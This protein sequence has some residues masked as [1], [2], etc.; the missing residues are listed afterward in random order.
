[1]HL[2]EKSSQ[3]EQIAEAQDD[4][5]GV[6]LVPAFTGLGAPYWNSEARGTLFGLT[7]ETGSAEIVRAG[8]EAVVYQ[9]ADLMQAM[10]ADG[11]EPHVLRVD[12]GMSKNGWLMQF[13]S[14]IAVIPL[15]RSANV[16]TTA[17]G[18]AM[19][20]GINIG[21][22]Q[23]E[24]ELNALRGAKTKFV[25]TMPEDVRSNYLKGWKAAVSATIA[26]AEALTGDS[27]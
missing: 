21:F 17:L 18:A 5:S 15:E 9:T 3:T 14:D 1:M 24:E 22:W 20:A 27:I 6:Y 16:E 7:R 10:S 8:L 13:A 19:L 23:D 26:H 4:N 11:L 2:I 25:T 12:G